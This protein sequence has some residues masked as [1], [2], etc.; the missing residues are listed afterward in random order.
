[1]KFVKTFRVVLLAVLVEGHVFAVFAQTHSCAAASHYKVIA[2]P[3][4]PARIN[5]SGL[6]VGTTAAVDTAPISEDHRPAVWTEKDGLRVV[7]LPAGFISAEPLG[8]NSAGDFVGTASREVN[9]FVAFAYLYLSGKFS[10]PAEQPEVHASRSRAMAINDSG[11]VAGQSGENLM[12]WRKQKALPLGGCC[13]GIAHGINNRGQVVG[14]VNDKEGHYSAFVWDTA[15][16]L[17][18]IAPPKSASS[19]AVAINQQGHVLLKS[20]T[21]NAVF[22]RRE[23]KLTKVELSPEFASQPLALNDCDVIVGE[24]GVS[25]EWNHAF[26]WD[27]AHGF[28]NL[29]TLVDVGQEW[30]LETALSIN[31]R[32]EIV[33]IGDRGGSQDV[34]Y[35]LVPDSAV[36]TKDTK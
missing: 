31:D 4:Q 21:P 24:F 23:G 12:V 28:R 22:L 35:L 36:A 2:L 19:M 6:I 32:G 15:H 9:Q 8:V 5:N 11:D 26:I 10:L 13:G 3:L 29:N 17:Q 7:E 25:S 33:G 1:L 14:Q 16:G 30:N 18:S 34:G 20:F 27:E